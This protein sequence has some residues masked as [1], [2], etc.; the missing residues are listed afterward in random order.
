MAEFFLD[1]SGYV[2]PVPLIKTEAKVKELSPGDELRIQTEHTRSAR[3]ILDWAWR[4][5]YPAEADERD[6]GTWLITIKKEGTR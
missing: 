1:L 4:R 5:G 6:D 2:C 3:N